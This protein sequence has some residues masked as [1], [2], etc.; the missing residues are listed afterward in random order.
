MGDLADGSGMMRSLSLPEGREDPLDILCLGAHCDDIEIGCGGTVLRLVEQYPDARFHW[1]V[2]ASNDVRAAEAQAAAEHFLD[3]AGKADIRIERFRESYFPWVGADIKDYFEELKADVD[4][5]LILTH[6]R[7]DRHQDHRLVADLTWNTWR[8]HLILEYE[9]P[10]YDGDLG[11]PNVF[12]TLD[13][14]TAQRKV[15][16]ILTHFPSQHR[17]AWFDADMFR[18]LL[19]LRGME[20]NAPGRFAEG[21][22]GTKVVL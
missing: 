12:V 19:R 21:F 17:R 7:H 16:G 13:E 22:Y 11:S 8:D 15:D 18:G 10:K 14:A 4:P 6:H 20:A 9:I 3:G 2:L 1:V 5:D